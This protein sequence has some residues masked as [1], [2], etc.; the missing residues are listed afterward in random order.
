MKSACAEI[1]AEAALRDA[2]GPRPRRADRL[3][4]LDDRPAR[5]ARAESALDIIV[6]GRAGEI[7]GRAPFR[8][9]QV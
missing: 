7:L 3:G 6:V 1:G 8:Q 4:R 9:A 5:A 2:R